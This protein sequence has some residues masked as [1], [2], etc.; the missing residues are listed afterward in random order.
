[1]RRL[2]INIASLRDWNGTPEAVGHRPNK[3]LGSTQ[4]LIRHEPPGNFILWF[5]PAR[6]RNFPNVPGESGFEIAEFPLLT[7]ERRAMG[8]TAGPHFALRISKGTRGYLG[9]KL[10]L[11]HQAL[12]RQTYAFTGCFQPVEVYVRGEVLLAGTSEHIGCHVVVLITPQGS[13]PSL[14]RKKFLTGQAII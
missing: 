7:T 13:Q 3:K 1:M 10:D 9:Q 2:T 11:R 14:G 5:A 6:E 4:R 8:D 12:R